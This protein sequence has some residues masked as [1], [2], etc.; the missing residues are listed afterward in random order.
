M[1]K[2]IIFCADGT[3]NGP[4]EPDCDD[5]SAIATN[6]FKTFLNLDGKDTPETYLLAKEQERILYDA[7]GTA[8]QVAK[9]LHGVGDSDN[10]LV[11]ALGGTVGAGLITRIVRGYTYVSRNYVSGDKIFLIGFSR[12]AYT[13]RALAGLIAAKG[14]LDRN[15][16]DLSD[17]EEA[18]RL[19]S[20]VWY[21]YRLS[22]LRADPNWL[23]R[24][25]QMV[26]DLPGFFARPPRAEQVVAC[27]IEA[28][29]VWD[30]VGALGIP[31][32]TLEMTHLDLFQFADLA[33]SQ[34]VHHGI[35]A[36][37][38]DEMREDFTPTLWDADPRIKQVLFAGAHSD[39]GGGYPY[40]N[41]CGL[42]DITLKWMTSELT[43]LGVRFSAT[44]AFEPKPDP[45]GPAHSPWAH[46]PWDVLARGARVFPRGL[47]LSQGV[48]DRVVAKS[49]IADFGS[50][51]LAPY[52]PRTLSE[53]I[54][55]RLAAAGVIVLP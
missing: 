33:L 4:G 22:A 9:Y 41:E 2:N 37:A 53:Y 38:V 36:I 12:G 31:A 20:A 13:A 51:G 21:E 3:W 48:L 16:L 43:A 24:L 5:K 45:I 19:G 15:T 30:T 6:V 14:L 8:E 54:T 7:N 55:G 17:K 23:S 11:K 35:H 39:V 52:D 28:V 46:P 29:A 26:L 44:P 32:Y 47:Y 40:G 1:V 27:P 49:V 34:V 10:F 18:Y 25:A 42:S 50:S